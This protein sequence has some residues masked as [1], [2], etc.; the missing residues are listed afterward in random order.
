MD[1]IFKKFN[2]DLR[3]TPYRV[4][5]TSRTEGLVEFVEA[6]CT[7]SKIIQDY[8][9]QT[10]KGGGL[11]AYLA[12]HNRGPKFGEQ[13]MSVAKENFV[14]S[15]AGY[16]V[17]T[18]VLGIGDRHLDNLLLTEKGH[19]FHI[20]FGYIFGADPKPWPP[21]MKIIMQMIDTMGGKDGEDYAHFKQLC[22]WAFNRLRSESRLILNQ[23]MLMKDMLEPSVC[24]NLLHVQ[25]KLA[26]DLSDSKAEELI[27]KQIDVSVNAILPQVF[28]HAHKIAVAWR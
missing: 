15:C 21:P 23:L 3:L 12:E 20:D 4:L 2:L 25:D 7:I 27:L 18:Y 22:C 5:A 24:D 6:S 9:T 14:R 8:P 10:S 16:C 1:G 28:E 17:I 19:L 13:E 11:L 26:L